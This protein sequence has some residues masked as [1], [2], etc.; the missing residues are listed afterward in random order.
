MNLQYD[1][2]CAKS[3][4]GVSMNQVVALGCLVRPGVRLH[5]YSYGKQ[6]IWDMDAEVQ[7]S[8][9]GAMAMT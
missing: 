4:V 1:G 9:A 8:P 6:V 2:K 5:W 7:H 3:S